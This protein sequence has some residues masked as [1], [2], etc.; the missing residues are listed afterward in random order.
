MEEARK[1]WIL[2]QRATGREIP[3]SMCVWSQNVAING[4]DRPR[5]YA[6]IRRV[7]RPGGRNA[8]R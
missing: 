3:A 7:L 1:A 4:A 5:L 2:R 6:G 8:R